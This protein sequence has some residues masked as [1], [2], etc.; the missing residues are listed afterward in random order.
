[1]DPIWAPALRSGTNERLREATGSALSELLDGLAHPVLQFNGPPFPTASLPSTS[2][3]GS[4]I[5]ARGFCVSPLHP[6]QSQSS[7]YLRDPPT[8]DISSNLVVS[9][10]SCVQRNHPTPLPPQSTASREIRLAPIKATSAAALPRRGPTPGR[11]PASAS[12][13]V[14][15]RLTA[16]HA[17]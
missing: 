14:S 4:R 10:A 8:C 2:L 16:P 7:H 9:H 5:A 17:F 12:A 11:S 15:D 3:A 1:M 13:S 6:P